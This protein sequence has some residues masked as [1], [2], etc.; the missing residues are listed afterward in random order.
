MKF[1]GT[2]F[3]INFK[4]TPRNITKNKGPSIGKGIFFRKNTQHDNFQDC[5]TL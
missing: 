3:K 1:G 5:Q 4:E 2:K